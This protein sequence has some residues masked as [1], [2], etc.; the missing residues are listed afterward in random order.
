[1]NITARDE[2]ARR[3]ERRTV[4]TGWK[5][6]LE[7]NRE[8]KDARLR[9]AYAWALD[10]F[11]GWCERQDLIPGRSAAR[12]FWVRAVRRKQRVKWQLRQWQEALEWYLDWQV[13]VERDGELDGTPTRAMRVKR[14]VFTTGA[15]RGLARTTR[16]TYAGWCARFAASCETDRE[17]LDVARARNWLSSLVDEQNLAYATQK[18][19]LN[20]LAFFYLDVCGWEEV[21]LRVEFRK[22]T[23]RVPVVLSIN[24]LRQFWEGLSGEYQLAAELMYGSGVRLAELVSLRVKDL[25]FERGQLVVRSGKGDKDR[26]TILPRSL[27]ERLQRHLADARRIHEADRAEGWPGV[28]MPKGLG[29]KYRSASVSWEWFWL[30]PAP[31]I[32]TDPDSGIR[33]RHHMHPKTLQRHVRRAARR[34]KIPKHITPHVM[35]H[36]FATHLLEAGSDIRTI[37]ELLGHAKVETTQRY[38][39]VAKNGNGPGT[40][41]PLDRAAENAG[42]EGAGDNPVKPLGSTDANGSGGHERGRAFA[43]TEPIREGPH[44]SPVGEQPATSAAGPTG[45]FQRSCRHIWEKLRRAVAVVTSALFLPSRQRPRDPAVWRQ[46]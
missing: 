29:Q 13:M 31:N 2:S 42:G 17:V 25:D 32:G 33:R 39:H 9:Q 37:Q 1:M 3:H 7:H 12:E 28:M 8:I 26:V 30:F 41:S 6:D 35:R 19:A 5:A 36:C 24:E 46:G 27:V 18:Q 38:T 44:R 20:A 45:R 22:T 11:L 4:W 23:P 16:K 40:T 10:W 43:P 34:A 21:D 14:A 15:R